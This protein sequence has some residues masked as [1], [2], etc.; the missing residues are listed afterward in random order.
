MLFIISIPVISLTLY[1]LG[2]VA[3]KMYNLTANGFEEIEKVL[4]YV[5]NVIF[6]QGSSKFELIIK[7]YENFYISVVIFIFF[8]MS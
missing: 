2:R 8:S 1:G 6:S 7:K 5:T 3:K 4:D